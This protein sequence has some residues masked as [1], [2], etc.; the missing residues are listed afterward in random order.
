MIK[1]NSAIKLS[2]IIPVYNEQGLLDATLTE[3]SFYLNQ[4]GLSNSTEVVIATTY[5]NGDK[6]LEIAKS[7][8][9]DF[10][11]YQVLDL[12][13]RLGKGRTVARGMKAATGEYKVFLD[14]DLAT[15][16]K[17]IAEMLEMLEAGNDVVIG[18]RDIKQMHKTFTRRLISVVSNGLIQFLAAPGIKDSQCGFKGF[19]AASAERIFSQQRIYGWGF[20]FETIAMARK[21]RYHIAM[22]EINDWSDPKGDNGLV[23]DSQLSAS[24]KT[25]K[26]LAVVKLNIWRKL[27]R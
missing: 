25:L 6:S 7:H 15:P 11:H 24:L 23:G 3:L 21:F 22:I 4:S 20:D 10:V 14:A 16:A 8:E 2:L 1:K 9:S 17:H 19:S 5:D 18:I 12:G 27:Y 26:E 13:G